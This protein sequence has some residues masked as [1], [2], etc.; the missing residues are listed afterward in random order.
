MVITG[1]SFQKAID[2]R[3]AF[4]DFDGAMVNVSIVLQ[5]AD[6][7]LLRIV[8]QSEVIIARHDRLVPHLY[9]HHHNY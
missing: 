7:V 3:T 1:S 9:H 4:V 6:P 8:R 5:R 2:N